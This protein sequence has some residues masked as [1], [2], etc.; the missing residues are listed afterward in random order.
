MKNYEANLD[1]AAEIYPEGEFPI[2]SQ[3]PQKNEEILD[4]FHSPKY[5]QRLQV[6]WTW[7]IWTAV[8]T[9]VYSGFNQW[10]V[11]S[12]GNKAQIKVLTLTPFLSCIGFVL[13]GSFSVSC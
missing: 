5:K 3:F 2:P 4:H 6:R 1:I 7:D 11:Y 12:F 10:N 9:R 13:M 8:D